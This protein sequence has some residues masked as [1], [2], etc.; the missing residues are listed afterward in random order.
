MSALGQISDGVRGRDPDVLRRPLA[1]VRSINAPGA[2]AGALVLL[3]LYAAF[4]H[5]AAQSPAETRLQLVVAVMAAIA[6]AAW[7]WSG[8]LRLAA[9]PSA[10]VAVGLLAAFSVW[11]GVTV[12]WS[13]A[14]DQTWI[15]LNRS[16]TY[17]IVLCLAICLGA[18][19]TRATEW[20]AGG[21]LAVASTVT[22]Y[23]LGQKL[24][25]GLHVPGV[26]SL[27]Q[28]GQVARLQEPFGYWNALAL[29]ITMGVPI[30][31]AAVVDLRRPRRLRVLALALI[32][33]MFLTIGFTYARG[34]LIATAAALVI[35]VAL[36]GS[37]LRALM[38]LTT[39]ALATV[40]PLAFGLISD[41][42]TSS[43]VSLTRREGAGA[44]LIGILAVSLLALIFA[45]RRVMSLEERTRL[46]PARTRSIARALIAVA[47]ACVV[48]GVVV[49]GLSSRGLTGTVSHAWHSFTATR[50]VSPTSPSRLLS[51]ASQNRWVWWKEALGAFSD[52]PVTGWGAGSFPV[53]HLLYRHDTVPVRQPHSVPLQWL[54]EIGLVGTL[55]ALGGAALLLSV[56]FRAVRRRPQGERVMAAALL[57]G[58][59]AYAAHAC[60]DWDA[61]IP[62]VTLP[63]LL[64]LGVLAGS[65]RAVGRPRPR[66]APSLDQRTTLPLSFAGSRA[67]LRIL[68]LAVLTL[69]LCAFALSVVLP[70]L[71]SD[72]AAGAEV[73]AATASRAGLLHAQSSTA[74]ASRLDPLSDAG[75]VA[76]STIAL[77][78]GEPR[79]ARRYL[80][81]AVRRQPTDAHAWVTL[82]YVDARLRDPQDAVAAARR[83]VALDPR[84]VRLE[85]TA[86]TIA[87]G[88]YTSE[89]QPQHSARRA[90]TP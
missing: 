34:G 72:K 29:F 45:A 38:W 74:L 24:L 3:I 78:R 80:L 60:Y 28:T 37:R 22:A 49:V 90:R 79:Q 7:L 52:R 31:L 36:S 39:A 84:D 67:G 65:T 63:V 71:A 47:A 26:F 59:A 75:L 76:E 25:P 82:A 53:V 46:T 9:P 12:V 20:A 19:S 56:G 88:A 18:S 66:G 30:A 41:A 62:G 81:A 50:V 32:E 4:S 86:A 27:N 13:I 61:D 51:A 6:G 69:G 54:A 73:A 87:D 83:A 48:V 23:A 42:L 58:G 57:A 14:P 77:H 44:V 85:H 68:A 43:P 40:P 15:E 64:F 55:L 89:A 17:L 11:T 35:V 2:L 33:L 5:G 1:G 16:I 10:W 8:T 70:D 21:F